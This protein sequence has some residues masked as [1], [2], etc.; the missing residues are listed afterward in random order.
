MSGREAARLRAGL[1]LRSRWRS[2]VALGAIAGIGGGVVIGLVSIARDTSSAIE[3]YIDRLGEPDVAVTICPPGTDAEAAEAGACFDYDPVHEAAALRRLPGVQAAAR[4]SPTPVAVRV[5]GGEW[6][7]SFAW[8]VHDPVEVFEHPPLVAGRASVPGRPDETMVNEAMAELLDLVPGGHLEVAPLAEA[9][10]SADV[11]TLAP[12]LPATDLEV[13]GVVR[14]GDDLVEPQTEGSLATIEAAMFLGSG[15]A[16][17]MAASDYFRYQTGVGLGLDEGVDVDVDALVAEA[18]PGQFH[19]VDG[20]L[21][22]DDTSGPGETV[23]Y[24]ARAALV[25]AALLALAWIVLVGQVLGRQARRELADADT[26]RALGMTRRSLSS[27]ALPRWIATAAIAGV[28]GAVTAVLVR[29]LGPVGIARRAAGAGQGVNLAVVGGGVLALVVFVVGVGLLVTYRGTAARRSARPRPTGF[30][31]PSRLSAEASVGMA[32]TVNAGQGR[33]S[34]A[35]G[36]AVLGSAA[37]IAAVIAVPTLH[38]S[39]DHLTG[40]PARYGVGWDAVATG[41]L[42]KASAQWMAGE[43]RT[44]DNVVAV[45]TSWGTSISLIDDRELYLYAFEAPPGLPAGIVPTITAGRAPAAVDEV[46]LGAQSLADAGAHIG[47]TVVVS[48]LDQE[49]PMRVVGTVVVNDN[50]EVDPGR[51]GVVT[52]EWLRM[53][54]PAGYPSDFMIRFADGHQADGLATLQQRFPGLVSAPLAQDDIVNLRRLESWPAVLAALT[55]LMAAA[56]FVHALVTSVRSQRH[57]LAV[58]KA[59]GWSRAQVGRSIFWH[60]S[61]LAL[62]AI[63][64]GVPAGVVLGRWGWGVVAHSLGVP[65]VPVVPI[66][67]L[68]AIAAVA[69]VGANV[70]AVWPSWRA[71]HITAADALRAE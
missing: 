37:A 13:T 28:V 32:L 59:L 42:G 65:S 69:L 66:A 23:D 34:W 16:D 11:A 43:L 50:Y 52:A 7:P 55:M 29:P 64:V 8:V 46:A 58:A 9:E 24:Q 12:E 63:L 54:D 61:F 10:A 36:P 30:I 33:R 1:L 2:A 35:A 15:W 6:R 26:L 47:D 38:S 20:G 44:V 48:A 22:A 5:P 41:V 27:S 53:A 45:A 57:P 60:A 56:A 39:L 4:V 31:L 14:V 25:A 68:L 17:A 19:A 62:P 21:T 71:A 40:D 67:V 70:L 18:A 49:Y 3:R 51:G